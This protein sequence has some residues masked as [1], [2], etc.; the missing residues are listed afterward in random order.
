MI[1]FFLFQTGL[2][3]R[4]D[5]SGRVVPADADLPVTMALHHH[6]DEPEVG[7]FKNI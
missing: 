5:F 1:F 4:F 2:Q 6:G 7:F 3:A